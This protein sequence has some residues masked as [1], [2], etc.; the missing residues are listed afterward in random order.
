MSTE[1]LEFL[2]KELEKL[3][4]EEHVSDLLNNGRYDEL[5]VVISEIDYE[6]FYKYM[7]SEE[8]NM[9]VS[10]I[11]VEYG[12]VHAIYLSGNENYGDDE[13]MEDYKEYAYFLYNYGD[14]GACIGSALLHGDYI[15][16]YD[17][18]RDL[19]EAGKKYLEKDAKDAE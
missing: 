2:N 5:D 19:V 15:C 7:E 10:E 11:P 17:S 14:A 18:I 4:K 16:K 3:E 9:E 1:F 13:V 6:Q 8:E 12:L